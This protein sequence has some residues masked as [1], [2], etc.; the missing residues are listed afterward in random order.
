MTTPAQEGINASK[1]DAY[2]QEIIAKLEN[3]DLHATYEYP[4][5]IACEEFN[6]GTVNG[7]WGV[8][9]GGNEYGHIIYFQESQL[10]PDAPVNEVVSFIL[11]FL[12][13]INGD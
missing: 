12:K 13:E 2:L 6:F 8:D 10:T 7:V 5:Y 3:F 9:D 4:G 1:R 11:N